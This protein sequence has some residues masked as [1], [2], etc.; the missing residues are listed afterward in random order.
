MGNVV[1]TLLVVGAGVMLAFQSPINAS[2]ARVVTPINAT[3]VSFT[4]GCVLA[5]LLSALLGKLPHLGRLGELSWWHF[6]GG[7]LGVAFISIVVVSMPKIG[8]VSIMVAALAGQLITAMMIDHFGW[9]GVVRQPITAA[10][11][12]ALPLLA[13]AVW[14]VQRR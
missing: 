12:L 9:I 6:L 1:Y 2:L 8:V 7:I 10:R 13:V 11:L 4:V 3:L 5:A 14:L